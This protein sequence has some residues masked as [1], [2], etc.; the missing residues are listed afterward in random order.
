MSIQS[1]AFALF[2]IYNKSVI[3]DAER[4][5]CAIDNPLISAFYHG[6]DQLENKFFSVSIITKNG[7]N[8]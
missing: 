3:I 6:V 5:F 1:I 4:D 7:K 8:D 2:L